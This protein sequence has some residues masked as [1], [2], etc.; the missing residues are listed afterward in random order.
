MSTLTFEKERRSS[1]VFL[2]AKMVAAGKNN[3]GKKFRQMCETLVVSAHGCLFCINQELEMGAELTVT[4]PF[5]QEDQECRVVYIG[6]ETEKGCRVGIEFLTP[7]PR[8]WGREFTLPVP[9]S[10]ISPN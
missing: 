9:S 3:R 5:T 1:R 2:R 10:M 8:F 4:S 7:A 6:E